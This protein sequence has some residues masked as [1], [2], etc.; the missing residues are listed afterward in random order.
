MFQSWN[1]LTRTNRNYEFISWRLSFIWFVGF[2]MRYCFL[3]PLRVI[4]CFIGVSTFIMAVLMKEV[5]CV[6]VINLNYLEMQDCV[7]SVPYC[8]QAD[9]NRGGWEISRATVPHGCKLDLDSRITVL[10]L[11]EFDAP[12][13]WLCM[14]HCCI[15]IRVL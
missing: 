2:L 1:L 9:F 7:S 15:A 8:C 6:I 3:L 5:H 12:L 11:Q 4:I 10:E 14:C 13:A